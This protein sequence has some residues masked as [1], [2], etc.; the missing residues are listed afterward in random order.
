MEEIS[1]ETKNRSFKPFPT[2]K[3][4]N[5]YHAMVEYLDNLYPCAKFKYNLPLCLI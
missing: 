3:L 5:F 1:G 2:N 4:N